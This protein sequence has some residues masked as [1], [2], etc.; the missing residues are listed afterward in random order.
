MPQPEDLVL[1]SVDDHVVEPPTLFDNHLPAKWK[2]YA[3]KSVHKDD[4]T[5]VWV[6]EGNEIPNIGL[7]A[8]AGRPPEEYNIE[9]TSYEMIRDGC[10]DIHERVKDMNRNGVLGSMCFPSFVQ[11][12]EVRR[13]AKKGCHAVTFS[14]N[15]YKLGWPHIFGGHWDPFFAA[16]EDEG[17]IICLHI[18]SSSTTLEIA[19]GAPIDIMI[20]LTPLNTMQAA[21]DLL[22]SRVLREF[23]N[24]QFALS[25]GGTGW[26]PYWL[27]RIDYT[28]QQHRFWTH[29]DFGDRLPSQVALDHFTFCFISDRA[30]VE[31]RHRIGIDNITWECDYPHSDSTWPHSPEAMAKQLEGIPE[32]EAAKLTYEN[33]MRIFR[34]DP[35]AHRAKDRATVGALRSEVNN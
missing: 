11:F 9:P 5:D 7:N 1:V 10:Y 23:P 2:Q 22:W 13:V 30:G 14:E 6:Y 31:D 35:F 29:Q 8:V 33:A 34:Y 27:E 20:T 28:Y 3:P 25:E 19:P 15:P 32:D 12:C 21:T 26:I 16:C 18:G 4:G 24:L 17:T